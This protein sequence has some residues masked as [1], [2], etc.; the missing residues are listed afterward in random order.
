MKNKKMIKILVSLL[1]VLMLIASILG[2]SA[3]KD[4]GNNSD[5][6]DV[7]SDGASDSATH[8]ENG[9][10]L[11]E[12]PRDLRYNGRDVSI[13]GW[14]SEVTEF[15]VEALNGIAI[16]EA[17][18]RRNQTVEARLD[19]SLKFNL[20]L[21]GNNNEAN[22]TAYT[23]H[24]E[25]SIISGPTYDIISAHTGCIATCAVNGLM[26]D[27]GA[28][29]NSYLDYDKPWWNSTVIDAASIG[30]TFYFITGDA[31]TSFAQMIYCVYFNVDKISELKLDSPYDLVSS[32]EWTYDE[33]IRMCMNVYSDN[34][35]SKTV[36]LEDEL[37]L[38]GQYYDW[39]SL[40]EGTGIELVTKDASG[41]FVLNDDIKG[42]KS[43]EV[44]GA[45]ADLVRLDGAYVARDEDILSNFMGG[46]SLFYIV[47]NGAAARWSFSNV[48]FN[49]GCVPLPKY[50]SVQPNYRC[51]VRKPISLFGMP[52]GNSSDRT[53]LASAVLE[54]YGSEGYR[55]TTPV[56]FEQVMKGQQSGSAQ[57][58]EMLMLIRDSA[59]FDVG[60]IY[61][62]EIG[63]LCDLPGWCLY[64]GDTWENYVNTRIPN[65]EK[66]LSQLS[67][68][69]IA[70]AN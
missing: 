16:D 65:V 43:M 38:V 24:L 13:L 34:N 51:A 21:L 2:C 12:L 28:L 10:L 44:M 70:V 31:S 60:R 9:Y 48:N 58:S 54:C 5:G 64:G 45:L 41:A 46:R 29:D 11:D 14:Q 26:Q 27:L 50:E 33:M 67:D 36:D 69:L 1:A 39:P 59:C 62:A 20:S 22:R 8:D 63:S 15:E 6:S 32:N 55:Q 40:L 66:L 53:E 56:I 42:A 68:D 18:Y 23:Q 25:N 57:M 3:K 35:N 61:A 49:Y 19:V 37:P 52:Y 30:N 7:V 47:Q 17:I 4:G